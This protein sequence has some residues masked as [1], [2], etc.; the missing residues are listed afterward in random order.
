MLSPSYTTTIL[1]I[2][3]LISEHSDRLHERPNASLP[4]NTQR[5]IL[6][7]MF[8]LRSTDVF[9]LVEKT[10]TILDP[11]PLLNVWKTGTIKIYTKAQ[12]YLI[13]C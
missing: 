9:N 4:L 3:I 5:N 8:N 2:I 1:I 10:I 13:S 7:R 11:I 12:K 6:A